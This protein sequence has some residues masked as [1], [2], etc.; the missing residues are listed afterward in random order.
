MI[1]DRT[2]AGSSPANSGC[3]AA[4]QAPNSSPS[5]A[6]APSATSARSTDGVTRTGN[7]WSSSLLAAAAAP[8]SGLSAPT[9][10]E[11]CPPAPLTRRR[12]E[13]TSFSPTPI[14]TTRRPPGSC[15]SRPPPSFSA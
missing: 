3:C 13:V 9:G 10:I 6:G 7:W 15:S 1:V 14:V 11:A 5:A 2:I 4:A 12:I 8:R